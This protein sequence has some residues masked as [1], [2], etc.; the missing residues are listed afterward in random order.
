MRKQESI[1]KLLVLVSDLDDALGESEPTSVVNIIDP[2]A[3]VLEISSCAK[4]CQELRGFLTQK[5]E[6]LNGGLQ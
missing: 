1:K 2:F 5:L 4:S 6:Q 3:R